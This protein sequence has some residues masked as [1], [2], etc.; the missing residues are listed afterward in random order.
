[1]TPPRVGGRGAE[2]MTDTPLVSIVT[3]SFDQ[4]RYLGDC[5]A[6]VQRQTYGAVEHVIADGGSTDETL[7]VLSGAPANVRWKSEPDRGQADA[8]NKA[9]ADAGGDIIGW[10]NSDDAYFDRR[11]IAGAVEVLRRRPEVDLVYGHAALVGADNEVLQLLWA[12]PF[13]ARLLR[14]VNFIVQPTVLIRRSALGETLV[15]EM[16][17]FVVDRELWMRLSREGRGFARL[18]LVV[19]IDRHHG[20]RKSHTIEDVGKREDDDVAATY[21]VPAGARRVIVPQAFRIASRL[22][23]TRL[24]RH[25][26]G[27]PAIDVRST[28]AATLLRRQLLTRRRDMPL[29]D[30]P[31]DP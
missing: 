21:G 29:L 7:D 30:E 2:L 8:I 27:A 3:P 31:G 23:G 13:S 16:L 14:Y 6:S 12:P 19:A 15:D 24:L 4:G 10:L 25:V 1:M 20:S 11:A 26:Q 22:L 9:F 28:R 17:E 5:I 18:D